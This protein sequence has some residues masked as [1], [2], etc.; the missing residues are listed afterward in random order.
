MSIAAIVYREILV[1]SRNPKIFA[2]RLVL[3][4]SIAVVW[5]L[6]SQMSSL[7]GPMSL[8]LL[9]YTA[10]TFF[11]LTAVFL[12][13]DTVS[14]ERRNRTLGLLLLTPLKPAE[15][16]LGKLFS[17]SSH[18]LF[19]LIAVAPIFALTLLR[20][21]LEWTDVV[22]ELVNVVSMV[23]LALTV[24]LFY[25]TIGHQKVFSVLLSLLTLG[26]CILVPRLGFWLYSHSFPY[27]TAFLEPFENQLL[28]A[29]LLTVVELLKW[30]YLWI[31]GSNF[32][33]GTILF[34]LA[35]KIFRINWRSE[36]DSNRSKS[37]LRNSVYRR[38]FASNHRSLKFQDRFNPY[39]YLFRNC[40]T[41]RL[42]RSTIVLIGATIYLSS[43]AAVPLAASFSDVDLYDSLLL[44]YLGLFLMEAIFR[45]YFYLDV[46]AQGHYLR[47]SGWFEL[48]ATAPNFAKE[49][50]EGIKT[51]PQRSR[52]I[53][54]YT[55]FGAHS[56]QWLLIITFAL[57]SDHHRFDGFEME[58]YALWL[59]FLHLMHC[60]LTYIEF[61]RF[62]PITMRLGIIEVFFGV[63]SFNRIIPVC[64]MMMILF[65]LSA[66]FF[67]VF[68]VGDFFELIWYF[69]RSDLDNIFEALAMWRILF[70]IFIL[71]IPNMDWQKS[72]EALQK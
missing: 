61:M 48:I 64:G 51:W 18:F 35:W 42:L 40:W 56:F 50:A 45:I 7:S 10:V 24:G 58:L 31:V 16:L 41:N 59:L 17:N 13:A 47:V 28:A 3:V 69:R 44:C 11:G 66:G 12:S 68:F 25:S 2:L 32:G 23:V 14:S 53:M 52:T 1:F 22:L 27:L 5:L 30:P 70:P 39:Y 71:F 43:V 21:G 20:G 6:S 33:I 37:G 46:L 55:L 19:C 34:L 54:F 60:G 4:G 72:K 67:V 9:T 38:F 36:T 65:F 15:L 29:K 57:F 62:E 49:F 63:R 8:R 26:G